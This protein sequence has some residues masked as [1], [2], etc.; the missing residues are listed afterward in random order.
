MKT[1][2]PS[3]PAGLLIDNNTI[4][5]AHTQSSTTGIWIR[6]KLEKPAAIKQ[7]KIYNRYGCCKDRMVGLSVYIKLDENIITSCGSIENT[8]DMYTFDCDGNGNVVELSAEGQ[9]QEQ[10]IAEIEVFG[11]PGGVY[12]INLLSN[13]APLSTYIYFR[14]YLYTGICIW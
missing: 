11:I 4:N 10:N 14:I 1:F 13:I 8:M 2:H 9:I 12:I 3:Y 7:I 6:V 5:F